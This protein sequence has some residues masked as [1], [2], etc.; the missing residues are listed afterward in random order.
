MFTEI[1]WVRQDHFFILNFIKT[2]QR[3]MY[4]VYMHYGWRV[5]DTTTWFTMYINIQIL[6]GEINVPVQLVIYMYLP[7]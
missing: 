2:V 7:R 5:L 1:D 3:D 4:K 6:Y